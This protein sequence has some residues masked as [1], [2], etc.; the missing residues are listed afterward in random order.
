MRLI[1]RWVEESAAHQ[2]KKPLQVIGLD[3][4]SY[5]RGKRVV[6]ST[7]RDFREK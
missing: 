4:V 1:E 3:E 7:R 5:G 6:S 2:F